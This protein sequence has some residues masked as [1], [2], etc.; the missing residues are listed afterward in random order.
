MP[1]RPSRRLRRPSA[2][3]LAAALAAAACASGNALAPSG[4]GARAG[5]AAA[6][7]APARAAERAAPRARQVILFLGDGMGL[8]TVTAA[9]ILEGQLRGESGEENRLAFEELP[10]V[11]LLKVYNTNQQV[12]DSAGTMT[13]IMTGVKTKAHVVALDDRAVVGDPA[14]AAGTRLRTLLEEAES[15]G[16]ATGIVTTTT[17]THATPAACYAHAPDRNWESDARLSPAA[18]AAGFPDIARQ[19]VEF[20]EGDG[21]DVVLGGG[22]AFFLPAGVS[23]PE[24]AGSTGERRDGRDLVAEWLARRRGGAYVWSRTQLEAVDAAATQRLLGLF[25][26][27]HMAFEADRA[28]DP[29]GEPSLSEMTAKAI[30]LLARD[31]D[32]FFLVVEGGRIDHAHHAG[33]A[34]RAL[35]ETIELSNA[36]RVALQRSEPAETLVVVTADHG[37]GMTIGGYPTRGNSILGLVAE[38]DASGRPTRRAARDA[39][40]RAYTT[41]GYAN[42]PG[43]SGAS[44]LQREGSKRMP[45]FPSRV[46]GIRAGR[47]DLA[48]V[49]PED[50]DYLQEATVPLLYASHSGEDVPL[51]AAGPGA[52]LFHGVQEQSYVKHAIATALGWADAAEELR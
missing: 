14:S 5:I 19:L 16:L 48:R 47:P 32:G 9:R 42:G 45:H 24:H 41:L 34:Y 51:Y 35:T 2:A 33:N 13:A 44:E 7:P 3:A 26:P 6:A 18:R 39:L 29:A 8:S 38:N 46:R 12:P 37:L 49:N 10:H 27:S 15:R 31:P 40:G 50:P 21:V 4:A 20:A 43:Y 17:V 1:H 30:E 28:L 25:S 11:A 36:V 52:A 22:R 23:D